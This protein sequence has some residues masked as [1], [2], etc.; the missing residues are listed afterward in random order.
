MKG[1]FICVPQHTCTCGNPPAA[2]EPRTS[3]LAKASTAADFCSAQRRHLDVPCL[4]ASPHARRA[5]RC[6]R[7]CLLPNLLSGTWFANCIHP[8]GHP[9]VFAEVKG[10]VTDLH[11]C[12]FRCNHPGIACRLVL[13]TH[14]RNSV[15]HCVARLHPQTGRMTRNSILAL[16]RWRFLSVSFLSV[17]FLM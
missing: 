6:Q 1:L 7:F 8:D 14:V 11:R 4:P 5:R 9:L 10:G 12:A 17:Q 15:W 2:V 13:P 16:A 3:L